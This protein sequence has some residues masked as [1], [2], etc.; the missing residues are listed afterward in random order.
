MA[1]IKP[2]ITQDELWAD[3]ALPANKQKPTLGKIEN[4]FSYGERPNHNV[5]NWFFEVTTQMLLHI[6]ENGVSEWSTDIVYQEGGLVHYSNKIY[7]STIATNSNIQP[8]TTADWSE[9]GAGGSGG[10][11][12]TY[13]NSNYNAQANDL[14]ITESL[15]A[16]LGT[17]VTAYTVTL[18]LT[19]PDETLIGVMDG[20]GNSQN[21]PILIDRNTATIDLAADDLTCDVDYFDIKLVY[22]QTT[23]NWALGG[24]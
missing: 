23:N 19:P 1:Q 10:M 15:G 18:P 6:Q 4:G 12:V 24:K 13:Q 8:G 3:S 14:I 9:F 17:G 20:S 11:N 2:V 21:R 16:T 5:F 7:Q 22:N